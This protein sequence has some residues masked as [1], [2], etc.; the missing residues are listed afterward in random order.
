M[1]EW[2]TSYPVMVMCDVGQ[3]DAILITQGFSQM[4]IDTGNEPE[5]I[6]RCL[7]SHLPFWDRQ[8]E[9]VVLTHPEVDHIG[10]F[11][12]IM[13]AYAVNML[14]VP[15]IGKDTNEFKNI[16]HTISE[17]PIK[18][19]TA[20]QGKALRLANAKINML[21]PP[22]QEASIWE[23]NYTYTYHNISSLT[24]EQKALIDAENP[25][26]MSIVLLVEFERVNVLLTGDISSEVELALIAQG[27]IEDVD[28]LKIAHHGSKTSSHDLFLERA[29]PDLAWISAGIENRYGHPH[30][31]V[32]ARLAERNIPMHRTDQDGSAQLMFRAG[33]V[34]AE[35][36]PQAPD[37]LSFALE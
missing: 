25:N 5:K 18:V 13:Q 30:P 3:G 36:F 2:P 34:I 7:G 6:M 31:S 27:L 4:L 37:W 17:S 9:L 14:L 26:E 35:K 29:N 22:P 16:Y 15:P 24:S 33:E 32:L 28:V 19:I 11:A 12:E 23:N 8:L 20:R 10:S 21:W 1:W